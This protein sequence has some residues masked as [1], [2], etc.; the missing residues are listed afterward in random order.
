MNTIN[1]FF[2]KV[3][4]VIKTKANQFDDFFSPIVSHRIFQISNALLLFLYLIVGPLIV[5]TMGIVG[6]SYLSNTDSTFI[7]DPNLIKWGGTVTIIYFVI[8]FITIIIRYWFNRFDYQ[9]LE[10]E[11][12]KVSSND[13][14]NKKAISTKSIKS[15]KSNSKAK[16]MTK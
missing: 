2:K 9:N 6:A 14:N 5:L 3:K 8:L 16:K 7:I 1:N 13:N 4:T 15:S 10:T 11:P 12:S